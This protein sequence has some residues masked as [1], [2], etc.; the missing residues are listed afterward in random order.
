MMAAKYSV[1]RIGAFGQCRLQYKY[2]YIDRLPSEMETIEAFMGSRVHESLKEL[3]D[4]VKNRRVESKDWLLSLYNEIWEKNFSGA[5]KVVKK[6]LAAEDYRKKG[7]ACLSDYYDEHRPFD[8]AKVVST[9]E[10]IAFSLKDG[11]EEFQFGGVLDR[12]DW[13]DRDKIFEIH[14]Y[15]TSG[16][17]LTQE[18]ADAD[19]QLPV[20]QIAIATRWPEAKQKARLV[21]HYL[22]FNKQVE[23]SRTAAELESLERELVRRIREIESSADFP[24]NRSALCEWC[25]YQVICPEWKHPKAIESLEPNAYLKD[26]GV[27]LVAKYVELETRKKE[28]QD[29]I[30]AV[31]VEQGKVKEAVLAF[32]EREKVHVLDGPG[33]RLQVAVKDE[34]AAPFKN[35]DEARWRGLRDFLI[36]EKKFSDVSTVNNMMLTSRMRDWP[37]EFIERMK[38]FLVRRVTKDVYLRKKG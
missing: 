4:R 6:D 23:S 3:Y 29:Q 35:E 20:Y 19:I 30:A 14:D 38:P 27:A 17:L 7:K 36:A 24:S 21:W 18:E 10:M 33:H 2:R 25:G 32:A 28:F 34:L 31:E 5:V 16:S 13:N 11:D 9:E 37:K 12:L 15:K 8:R 26:P 1:S 22:L